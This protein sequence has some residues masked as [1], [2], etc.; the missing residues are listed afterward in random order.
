MS[1]EG[2]GRTPV[3]TL[4]TRQSSVASSKSSE[5]RDYFWPGDHRSVASDTTV[6]SDLSEYSGL[7]PSVVDIP[8]SEPDGESLGST[9]STRSADSKSEDLSFISH[10]ESIHESPVIQ[11][12]FMSERQAG[13]EVVPQ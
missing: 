1:S 6:L 3:S 8:V 10:S 4:S 9:D 13:S 2:S 11:T 5:Y 7:P 12:F